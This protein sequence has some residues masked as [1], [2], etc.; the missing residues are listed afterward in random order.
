MGKQASTIKEAKTI[1]MTVEDMKELIKDLPDDMQVYV[2]LNDALLPVCLIQSEV[3]NMMATDKEIEMG[4]PEIMLLLA[5]CTCDGE[6]ILP[7]DVA[8]S[9]PINGN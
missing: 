8:N 7:E 3:V 9:Y 4:L 5:P 2:E 6:D 1:S